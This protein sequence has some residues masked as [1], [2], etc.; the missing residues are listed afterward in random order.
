MPI[1]AASMARDLDAMVLDVADGDPHLLAELVG[2]VAG[3]GV[4]RY[5]D[6]AGADEALAQLK[7]AIEQYGTAAK[8]EAAGNVVPFPGAAN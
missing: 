5:C 8:M 7:H 1:D 3:W 6:I 4:T 2:I